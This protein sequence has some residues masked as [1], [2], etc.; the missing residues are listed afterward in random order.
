MSHDTHKR[1]WLLA[2]LTDIQS[3]TCRKT[4]GLT[5]ICDWLFRRVL[6]GAGT[7]LKSAAGPSEQC[8]SQ[9]A[10]L[11]AVSCSISHN[12]PIENALAYNFNQKNHAEA[13][14]IQMR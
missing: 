11:P 3:C 12:L 14:L 2:L 13:V 9:R 7:P 1:A 5:P 10:R 8:G 6:A 4:A